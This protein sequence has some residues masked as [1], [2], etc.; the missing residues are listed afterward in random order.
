MSIRID[1]VWLTPMNDAGVTGLSEHGAL[2]PSVSGNESGTLGESL[3]RARQ[4]RGLTG[5]QIAATTRIPVRL[6]EALERDD[7]HATPGGM[8][9]RAEVLAYA[10]VVGLDRDDALECL[11][12]AIAPPSADRIAEQPTLSQPSRRAARWSAVLVGMCLATAIAFWRWGGDGESVTSRL[13]QPAALHETAAAT[14]G[15]AEPT[16]AAM[17]VLATARDTIAKSPI[18]EPELEIVTEPAGA[19]V[20]VDGVG[21]G[22]SPVTIKYLPPGNKRLRITSDGFVADERVIRLVPGSGRTTVAVTLQQA[23]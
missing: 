13:V 6:L 2:P 5:P 12:R 8:Y 4:Q 21:W 20:T 23:D 15:R 9:L 14:T 7:T 18:V 19:H 22:T 11:R 10:E 3:R 16:R 17:P 1:I